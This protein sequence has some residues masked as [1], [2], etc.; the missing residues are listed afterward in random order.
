MR[1]RYS[2][3]QVEKAMQAFALDVL[4]MT[5]NMLGKEYKGEFDVTT[6]SNGAVKRLKVDKY[7]F[8]FYNKH[9][10]VD[11]KLLSGKVLK[12]PIWFDIEHKY[13]SDSPDSSKITFFE[14]SEG[15]KDRYCH[16]D[17]ILKFLA[18]LMDGEK[19]ELRFSLEQ[20]ALKHQPA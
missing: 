20:Y 17:M 8:R 3:A 2:F 14:D 1:S 9:V 16:K 11:F 19:P 6:W 5:A 13:Y 12:R 4:V 18:E 15:V 7:E 10:S